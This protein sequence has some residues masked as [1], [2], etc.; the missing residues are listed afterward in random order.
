MASPLGNSRPEKLDG[1]E[2]PGF[3]FCLLY[4]I[5]GLGQATNVEVSE[6]IDNKSLRKSL[7]SVTKEPG[8]GKISKTVNF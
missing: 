1:S 7:L 2:F 8:K 3:S 6:S 5:L 4:L